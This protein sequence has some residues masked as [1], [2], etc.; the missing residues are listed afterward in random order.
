MKT[1]AYKKINAFTSRFSSGNPAACLYLESRRS[2]PESAMLAIAGEHKG[3]VSEV[4]YCSPLGPAHYA[5][6]YYSSECEVEFCG[7]GTIAC[8]Y[9]LIRND[10][11]LIGIPEI[12]IETLKGDLVVYNE[13][14]ALDAVFVTAPDKSEHAVRA[15]KE[16]IARALGVPRE[17]IDGGFAMECVNAGLRT[18]IVPITTLR[19]ILSMNPNEPGLKEFCL[20]NEID[21]ILVFTNAVISRENKIRT[22]VFAPKYGYLE[23]VA[24]GSGNSAM[25]YYMLKNG[26]WDGRAISIEQNK[27]ETAYNVVRLKEKAGKVLFGGRATTKIEG[28][29]IV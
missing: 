23:D 26:M 27:E 10:S 7:H 29:Y 2:L 25:G 1:F 15:G 17:D 9:D 24:T 21:I 22:R 16:D 19:A 11:A 28:R 3:F 6:R 12:R 4:V 14:Q 8:M 13:I 5:L 20:K 18:L